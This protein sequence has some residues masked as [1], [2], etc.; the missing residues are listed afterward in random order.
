[1]TSGGLWIR[2]RTRSDRW[3][4]EGCGETWP[5]SEHLSSLEKPKKGEAMPM[6]IN[7]KDLFDELPEKEKEL[8]RKR[9]D[10]LYQEVTK[11]VTATFCAPKKSILKSPKKPTRR[12]PIAGSESK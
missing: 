8:I 10:V 7:A 4:E 9:A 6:A 3:A 2:L 11:G 5:H 1:M 12:G